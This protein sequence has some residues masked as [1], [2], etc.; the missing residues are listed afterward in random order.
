MSTDAAAT[1]LLSTVAVGLGA[2]VFMDL[3]ALL[4]KRAFGTPSANYCLVGRWF[5]HMP[6]GTFV[7]MSIANFA[8]A[9]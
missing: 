6:E 2:T 5:R 8:K 3:W 4:L 7:H 1:Y 9:L